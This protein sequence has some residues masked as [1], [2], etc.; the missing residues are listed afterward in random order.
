MALIRSRQITQ[1][2]S[3]GD[4]D[5]LIAS[6]VIGGDRITSGEITETQLATSIAG[7]GLAGGG[8][9][10]LAVNTSTGLTTSADNVIID[11]ASTVDFSSSTPVWT[12]GNETT[13]EGLFVTGTPI[14]ANHVPNKTY[15]D[16][17]AT[18]LSWKDS[19]CVTALI[20]ERTIVQTNALTPA[21]GDAVIAADSG[22]PSSGTSDALTIG[23]LAEYDGTSWK[24]LY[25]AVASQ[26]PVGIRAVLSTTQTLTSPFTDTTDDGKIVISV[27]TPGTFD[28]ASSDWDDTGDA[29]DSNAVLVQCL[30]TAA[31]ESVNENNGYV[32]DGAVPTGSWI[33]FTGAGQINAGA[34]L[35][36]SG[37]TLSVNVGDLIQGGS[38]EIDGDFLDIDFTPTNYT[39]A[40]GT[41]GGVTSVL[42]DHL[43]AHL[44]GI[45]NALSAAPGGSLSKN[46]VTG[47]AASGTNVDTT[48][49][50]TGLDLS[51]DDEPLVFVNGLSYDVEFAGSGVGPFFVRNTGGGTIVTSAAAI[52]ATDE[53]FVNT[54]ALGFDI[55]AADLTEMVIRK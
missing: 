31:A 18:G 19:V 23:D 48:I 32:Y 30:E 37:N 2:A 10:A 46:N 45:D 41:V 42:V 24:K 27:A 6:G 11:V 22:T 53:L 34:G 4:L 55:I 14:D 3:A 54:T 28:G 39:E 12:F 8:G 36:K 51:S 47:L 13:A 50:F 9:S 29:V 40:T 21:L 1:I 52:V 20:G 15:V 38:A 25:D 7:D 44:G 5:A 16:S 33:Q 49:T 17:I 43:T 26:L 35:S